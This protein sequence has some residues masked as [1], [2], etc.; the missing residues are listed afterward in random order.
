MEPLVSNDTLGSGIYINS[1]PLDSIT[2]D[3]DEGFNEDFGSLSQA[4]P[5]GIGESSYDDY[6][7][8]SSEVS[9]TSSGTPK[10]VDSGHDS[11]TDLYTCVGC[12]SGYTLTKDPNNVLVSKC[13][14][15]RNVNVNAT[16]RIAVVKHKGTYGMMRIKHALLGSLLGRSSGNMP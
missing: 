13:I 7:Y 4:A 15:K 6:S 14:T 9:D 1:T 11:Y 2:F 8:E 12:Q 3:P 10:I 5:A 16:T